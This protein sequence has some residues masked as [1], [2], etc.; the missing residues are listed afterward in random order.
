MHRRPSGFRCIFLLVGKERGIL[1]VIP[2]ICDLHGGQVVEK[3]ASLYWAWVLADGHRRAWKQKVCADCVREHY[4]PLIIAGE[5]PVLVCPACGI[6]TVDDM[7]AIYLTYCLPGMPQGQSEL[8][9][10]G[11]CAVELR[12][13]ALAGAAELPDRGVGVG[14]PQPDAVSAASTWASL[15]IV[16]R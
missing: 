1:A 5:Q 6:S 7:D 14:G 11:P 12:N 2:K 10:C 13:K 9:M 3:L 15:G 4:V 8:P 16:P